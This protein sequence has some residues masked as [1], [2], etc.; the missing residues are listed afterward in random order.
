MD[1]LQFERKIPEEAKL[2]RNTIQKFIKKHG[3]ISKVNQWWKDEMFPKEEIVSLFRELGLMQIDTMVDEQYGCQKVSHLTY[4]LL[5]ELIEAVDSGLRSFLSVNKALVRFAIHQ[6]G[7][8]EQKEKYLPPLADGSKIGCFGL[9]GSHGGSDPKWM[10]QRAIID[11]EKVILQGDKNWIT[12]GSIA[13]FAVVYMQTGTIGDPKTVYGFIVERDMPGFDQF[14]IKDKYTL[15]ASDTG[16]LSFSNCVLH[17][18][19]ALLPTTKE[20][21]LSAAYDSLNGA[22]YTIGW[23]AIGIAK[24]CFLEAKKFAAEERMIRDD[25]GKLFPLIQDKLMQTYFA[26]MGAHIAAMESLAWHAAELIDEKGG[27]PKNIAPVIS[28]LKLENV[29]RAIAV[30][31]MAERILASHGFQAGKKQVVRHAI[32]LK[33]LRTYEGTREMHKLVLGKYFTQ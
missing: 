33:T 2:M 18:K 17:L 9:T 5:M 24:A 1:L 11:G 7:S 26:E 23:G 22:R 13:D 6:F 32:N 28:L 19:D 27:I 30:A 10:N 29:D 14:P 25:N 3:L 15:K 21:G 20:L 16:S 4:G 31:D 12:N 8:E